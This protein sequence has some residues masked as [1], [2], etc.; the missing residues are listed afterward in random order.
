M[1]R[2]LLIL[3]ILLL[4]LFEF[5]SVY[6]I[7]PFPGSQEKNTLPAAYW[8]HNNI[9]WIRFLLLA[10]IFWLSLPIFRSSKKL[11]KI[12]VVAVLLLFGAIYYMVHY[13]M[14][15]DHM[16]YQ[17]NQLS[18]ENMEKNK[19]PSQ[20]LVIAVLK[21][22]VAKAY[23][24][25]LIGY[26]H[27][28]RDSIGS[29]PIMVTYCTVCRT[30]RVFN[31]VVNGKVENFRLVGMDHFNAMFEDETTR[32]WWQQA[33]GVAVAGPLK[34]KKLEEIPS[35]QM[36]L[37]AWL[38]ENPNSLVM[39]EDS[40]FKEIYKKMDSYDKGT[41]KGQL[42]RRDSSSWNPKSWVLGVDFG[43]TAKAY[44]WNE[45]QQKRLITDSFHGRS[46][47]L[48]LE[49]DSSSFHAYD[50]KLDQQVL[51]FA[52]QDSVMK[53]IQT[54]SY[55]NAEGWATEGPLK[56]RKLDLVPVYQEFWHSWQQFHPGSLK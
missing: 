42:T 22:G 43:T 27:Q 29:N 40:A 30:G 9:G 28:V 47:V 38:R 31:P 53:D 19:I 17:P 34:G 18:M 52:L 8:L 7:M 54:G 20:K 2:F 37:E 24:I 56:G 10:A 14:R 49:K 44:D 11:P 41:G 23:P 16:F 6:L 5:A 15:A 26:H 25:Q 50:R 35:R 21:D 1:K 12:I 13:Q 39:Q 33:T 32:S 45:L 46:I 4:F 51:Q 3:A 55:W 36:S 48:F